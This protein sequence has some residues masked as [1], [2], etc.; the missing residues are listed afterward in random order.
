MLAIRFELRPKANGGLATLLRDHPLLNHRGV[1]SWPPTWTWVGGSENKHPRGEIGIL[2]AVEKSKIQPAD[3]CFLF[4]E[5]E[6][7]AFIG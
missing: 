1:P 7:A 5:H 3:K 4:I 2:R 6:G